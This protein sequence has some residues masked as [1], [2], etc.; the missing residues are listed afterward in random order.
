M[1]AKRLPAL[2]SALRRWRPAAA[3]QLST[4]SG[5]DGPPGRRPDSTPS[6]LRP[7]R[8]KQ[9]IFAELFPSETA[10]GNGAAAKREP[11]TLPPSSPDLYEEFKDFLDALPPAAAPTPAADADAAPSATLVLSGTTPTLQ[12]SDFA[13]LAPQGAHM[14]GWA[15]GFSS[16]QQFRD[17]HTLEPRGSYALRFETPGAAAA[18]AVDARRRHLLACR[19]VWPRRRRNNGGAL[20]RDAQPVRPY[21]LDDEDVG[22]DD[23]ADPRDA[24]A[25]ALAPPVGSLELEF[26]E[27]V[28]WMARR[29]SP[30]GPRPAR[31]PPAVQRD[32]LRLFRGAGASTDIGARVLVALQGG[33]M[34]A[35]GLR[36]VVRADGADRNLSW[37]LLDGVEAVLPVPWLTAATKRL[38]KAEPSTL[39]RLLEAGPPDDGELHVRFV[40]SF[41]EAVEARRFARNWHRRRTKSPDTSRDVL[42]NATCLW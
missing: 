40:V 23:G 2:Q 11:L 31:P 36:D 38:G 27:G 5:G 9:S 37:A 14:D 24:A 20:S 8:E 10:N 19:A 17:A 34:T 18:Y 39:S 22:G 1:L 32:P 25:F 35:W 3:R 28:E 13:R 33:E 42:V 7:S 26:G 4:S 21:E 29:L 15:A 41:R 6:P 12:Q 16:V 30:A